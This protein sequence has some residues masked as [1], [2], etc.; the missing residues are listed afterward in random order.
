M[1]RHLKLIGTVF[2]LVLAAGLLASIASGKDGAAGEKK[3]TGLA[4][5]LA[6]ELGPGVEVALQ[7]ETGSVRFVG[8]AP[9]RSIPRP[10]GLSPA[11]SPAAVARAFLGLH[12]EAFGLGAGP[13]A[14]RVTGVAASPGGKVAVRLQQMID[15]VPVLAGEF[16]VTVDSHG[17]VLSTLGEAEPD[18][19]DTVAAIGSEE[20]RR[21]AIASVAK[22]GPQRASALRASQPR[23]AVYDSR[24]LGGP[25]LGVPLLVWSTEISSAEPFRRELVLIDADLGVVAE[26]IDLVQ[27]LKDRRVCDAAN[28]DG[29]KAGRYPCV[30]PYD[31]QEGG[32]ETG[33][34]DIDGAYRFAGDTYDFYFNRFGRDSLDGAGLPLLSTV[35]YCEPGASC[36]YGNA[37]WDGA[38]M[39]YGEGFAAADD[40]VGHELSHG[41]TQFT[42]N[43]FYWFQSGAINES[44]SDVFGEY[45]DLLNGAGTDT[46]ATRWLIGEDIPGV[47]AFRDMQD[48]PVYKDPDRMTSS[49]Y[50]AD[51]DQADSGGVHTNSGV[52]NKAAALIADGGTFNGQTVSGIGI[53]KAARVYYAAETTQ[54][55]SGS[56]YADLHAA[57]RQACLN[58]IGGSEG[59]T[60]AD[61]QEVADAVSAT[62]MDEQPAGAPASEAPVCGGST[63]PVSLFFDDLEN[64]ASGNWTHS[65]LS[66]SDGWYYPQNP[67]P[68]PDF[69]PTYATSGKTN[70]W[71]Y[72]LPTAADYAIAQTSDTA[73][74]A[75]AAYL[76]F[77]HSYAF[78]DKTKDG[79]RYDGGRLE[80]S[81]NGGSTWNDAGALFTH[82]G[83]NG[84]ITK[85]T[86]N[87]LAGKS[88]FTAESNGYISSRVDLSSLAGKQVRFRFRIGT[89][90]AVDDY[91]WFIDDVSI[92]LCGDDEPPAAPTLTAVEPAS[93]ANDNAPKV[94]GSAEAGSTVRLYKAPTA[95][96]CTPI[97]LAASGSASAF[98]SPGLAVSVPSDSSTTF[99]ASAEDAAGNV[100]PCSSSS[101]VYVEDST[102]PSNPT[103]S[104]PS[105]QVATLSADRT[106]EVAFIGASDTL[107]GLDGF[108]YHWDTSAASAADTTK[109]AEENATGT[110]SPALADGSSH[111]I[112]LRSRDNAGNWSATVHLG[113]F[114]IDATAPAAPTLT[115]IEP[116]SPANDNA[117]K[118]KGSAEAGSTVHLYKAPTASDCTPINLAASGSASSFA[119]PGLAAAVPN[120]S[121]TVFR[122]SAEDAAGNVSPCSSSSIVYVEDS[123]PPETT[124]DSGPGQGA[125]IADVTPTF[126]FSSSEGGSTFQCSLDSGAFSPCGSPYTTVE[127]TEGAHDFAVK[128]TDKVGN[129]DSSAAT[130]AF[131]VD[132]SA[133]GDDEPPAA[134]T[135][136][137]IEPASPAN[138]NAPKLKGSAEAG[139]TV[140]LYKAP[141]AS[142][143]TPIN[144]AASGSASS[145]ASPG[146]AA[147][148]PNDSST[149]FR[150]SAE[151]AAGNVSPCSSSSIAYV[152]D[153]TPPETAIDGSPPA[154]LDSGSASFD[155]SGSDPGGSG[156][157]SYSCR[158]DS[159]EEGAWAP[160]VSPLAY[161]SL[162]DGSHRFEVRATDHVGNADPTPA[163]REFTIDTNVEPD[164]GQEPTPAPGSIPIAPLAVPQLLPVDD[165]PPQAQLSAPRGQLVGAPVKLRVSCDE[166][167]KVLASGRL[168]AWRTG[169]GRMAGTAT[170]RAERFELRAVATRL[171]AGQI[172]TLRL[173][174]KKGD[175]A[176]RRV[177]RLSQR[178]WSVK[179]AVLAVFED[180][181]GNATTRRLAIQL[182]AESRKRR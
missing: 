143:C 28:T 156:I 125:T 30:A 32:A 98:S 63:S 180:R 86:G 54:L 123:T 43:L 132:S 8:A 116:A 144:L 181:S 71:G 33:K 51:P 52:G 107:S 7:R 13:Q 87:P 108:S 131:T 65:M 59:I 25:G 20:A 150:A 31:R 39:A 158:L 74:P 12:H 26:T 77:D 83:Y 175:D 55:T 101:I 38:Q 171:D 67:N 9:S 88:A 162:A 61:C 22:G 165:V 133:P 118:V 46:S 100:S 152:E 149:V 45:I 172:A 11:A 170:L 57:L 53:A 72:D 145:F 93:P 21:A 99:R 155:F 10:A 90:A 176:T 96:D 29:S 121:S 44:M 142:D 136:T 138:D 48:P 47:G 36:P 110:T 112:H 153:S 18:P 91:G 146:L 15:E 115:A 147:A 56:D 92:Y 177:L 134:P 135:L 166:E 19:V 80:Y 154:L 130:R 159:T 126:S 94:K 163:W 42:S 62:E 161:D 122:A 168:I 114:A 178:G 16:A 84:T 69:D 85:N 104:S 76:R 23:L 105:H 78:E 182:L 58:S 2:C 4:A 113:P 95:S 24:L 109:E 106:V 119:S 127:L 66:G 120:D 1:R 139:S 5:R 17:N 103:L 64:P 102:P 179:A 81:T 137:A 70:L 41:F 160:C 79:T 129:V 128:A 164:P 35:R 174:P 89:D 117:P 140:R 34:A 50:A 124:I 173:E 141:T 151:D 27:E 49:L 82:N 3:G 169:S 75:G 60:A 68:F 97:N 73:I 111:Y 40:V 37:F 6:G 14:V 167:C 148:V 157:E